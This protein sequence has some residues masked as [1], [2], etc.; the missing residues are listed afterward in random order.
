MMK[1]T[2]PLPDHTKAEVTEDGKIIIE[3]NEKETKRDLWLNQFSI[4]LEDETE[5]LIDSR[6]LRLENNR[7]LSLSKMR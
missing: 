7:K 2:I 1:M 5:K 3:F 4:F 6:N